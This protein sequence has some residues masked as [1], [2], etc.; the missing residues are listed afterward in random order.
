MDTHK[1]E[2]AFLARS[3]RRGTSELRSR[4]HSVRD[5]D[6]VQGVQLCA[7]ISACLDAIDRR[8]ADL[9]DRST[10][11]L[12]ESDAAAIT[13]ELR[14]LNAATRSLHLAGKW[15]KEAHHVPTDVALLFFLDKAAAALL[16]VDVE[17]ITARDDRYMFSSLALDRPF[18]ELLEDLNSPLPEGPTPIL[19]NFPTSEIH[20]VLL[21]PVFVHELGHDAIAKHGLRKAVFSSY[22]DLDRL[23]KDFS[24]AVASYTA[25]AADVGESLSEEEAGSGLRSILHDWVDELLCDQMALLFAGPSY[26]FAAAGFLLPAAAPLPSGTHPSVSLRL[27]ALLQSLGATKWRPMLESALPNTMEWLD[28]VAAR[29]STLEWP[30][31]M[32]FVASATESLGETIGSVV[33]G[34]LKGATY[35]PSAFSESSNEISL[36]IKHQVLP[37][38]LDSGRPPDPRGVLLSAW[39]RKLEEAEDSPEGI[40]AAIADS[41]FQEFISQSL[42]MSCILARWRQ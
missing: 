22:P 27:G 16:Q 9:E 42:E 10:A 19:L 6:D 1:Q 23:Q 33:S 4:V 21:H 35:E 2:A 25:A 29:R 26:L 3:C 39:L 11:P 15:L 18:S 14:L 20:T 41:D 17:F 34:H 13:S 32:K 12:S 8:L 5:A 28:T 38:Q 7:Y 31:F 30:E 37:A 36:M 40:A 24:D